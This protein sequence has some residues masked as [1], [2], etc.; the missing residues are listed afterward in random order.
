METLWLYPNNNPPFTIPS[1]GFLRI[2]DGSITNATQ[3]DFT[4][5][6]TPSNTT[7]GISYFELLTV[8][9]VNDGGL[10]ATLISFTGN[11]A[12]FI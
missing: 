8:L 3:R 11:L 4:I 12:S 5:N 6:T 2:V 7:G 1:D 10:E 9:E